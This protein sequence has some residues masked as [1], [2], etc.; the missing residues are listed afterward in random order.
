MRRLA[1]LLVL[2]PGAALAHASERM[3]ILTLPTGW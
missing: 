3:V 2:W 1:A